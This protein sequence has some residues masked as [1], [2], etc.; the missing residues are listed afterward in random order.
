[1][2]QQRNNA[3]PEEQMWV[4]L[5]KEK[6]LEQFALVIQLMGADQVKAKCADGIER[7]C[8]IPGKMKK[9]VWMRQGDI[10]IIK[11][12]DFQPSKAD[13]VWRFMGNQK[14]WLKRKGYLK[15]LPV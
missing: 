7:S 3:N 4:R 11:V 10:L 13:V 6:D 14:E 12:W 8:R 2:P 15:N 5:P 1:M 9:K